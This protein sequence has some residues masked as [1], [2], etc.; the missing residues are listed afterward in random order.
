MFQVRNKGEGMMRSGGI[1]WLA[2]L[3]AAVAIYAVGFV[4]Y[5]MLIPA[6]TWM[7]WE[8]VSEAE[9]AAGEARMMFSPIM[10]LMTAVFLAV[11]FKW[12]QV[13]SVSTGI[14]WAAVVALAS[15]VPTELYAWVY[16]T[17]AIQVT[18]VD[19]VHLLLGHSVAGAILGG[20]K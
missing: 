11:L 7:A 19:A 16:G 9:L 18:V 13:A 15:A 17:G 6:E 12:G 3:A 10:P 5:A 14:R 2:A 4:I 1:N 20:W 8:G